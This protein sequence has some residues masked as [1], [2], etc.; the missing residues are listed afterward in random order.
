ML[1]VTTEFQDK[2]TLSKLAQSQ[3]FAFELCFFLFILGCSIIQQ[4]IIY[5]DFFSI[6]FSL[7]SFVITSFSQP[8][9]LTKKNNNKYELDYLTSIS[10]TGQTNYQKTILNSKLRKYFLNFVSIM[11]FLI[12]LTTAMQLISRHSIRILPILFFPY[13]SSPTILKF[14]PI[15]NR[16]NRYYY[17]LNKNSNTFCPLCLKY[18][19]KEIIENI[20]HFL[21]VCPSYEKDRIIFHNKLKEINLNHLI[22]KQESLKLFSLINNREIY[23]LRHKFPK[24][25]VSIRA[26]RVFLLRLVLFKGWSFEKT[27]DYGIVVHTPKKTLKIF[28]YKAIKCAFYSVFIPILVVKKT[29]RIICINW[30]RIFAIFV[31]IDICILLFAQ[32]ISKSYAVSFSKKMYFLSKNSNSNKHINAKQEDNNINNNNNSD[33]NISNNN[34]SNQNKN[35]NCKQKTYT[36]TQ[37]QSQHSKKNQNKKNKNKKSKNDNHGNNNTNNNNNSYEL[38]FNREE[39]NANNLILN[40]KEST[41][42]EKNIEHNDVNNNTLDT[43]ENE[44]QRTT[45]ILITKLHKFAF[46]L[47]IFQFFL[48]CTQCAVFFT[49]KHQ[50]FSNGILVVCNYFILYFCLRVRRGILFLSL[51][52]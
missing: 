21:W 14:R 27:N 38:N 25:I 4:S 10:Q 50:Y 31:S 12:F 34:N 52:L 45:D 3:R 42:D 5:G 24:G 48:V 19:E 36:Q 23:D 7:L 16:L 35:E 13:P 41:D 2:Q 39:S 17:V 1:R 9:L 33:N 8:I 44:E 6:D 18:E 30:C 43:E 51:C 20:D 32:H 47:V 46:W 40:S 37:S 49:M 28:M 22:L 26:A 15:T 11:L 29:H